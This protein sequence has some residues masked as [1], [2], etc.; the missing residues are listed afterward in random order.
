MSQVVSIAGYRNRRKD[1]YLERFG[2]HL[3]RFLF[4]FVQRNFQMDFHGFTSIYQE[5]RR[6]QS[7]AAWDYLDLRDCLQDLIEEEF[8]P[9]LEQALASEWWY[10]ARWLTRNEILERL[11]SIYIEGQINPIA[12]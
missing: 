4:H 5:Q 12:L 2:K 10:D 1:A 6:H 11:L 8:V 3:D 7:E 9:Q